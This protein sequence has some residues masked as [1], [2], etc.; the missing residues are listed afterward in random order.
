MI[1]KNQHIKTNQTLSIHLHEEKFYFPGETIKGTV[2]VHPKSPT[3]TNH[4]LLR[5]KGQVILSIKDKKSMTLFDIKKIL[6]DGQPGKV[7]ILEPKK[8]LFPF[9]F[10]VPSNLQLPSSMEYRKKAKVCY[11]LIVVHDR[12]MMLESL[13]P[14]IKYTVPVL[15]LIDIK[16]YHFKCIKERAANIVLPHACYPEKCY[17]QVSIAQYGFTRGDIASIEIVASHF[18]PYVLENA[19]TVELV[20]TIEIRT[21]RYSELKEDILRSVHHGLKIIGPYNFS[22]AIT[23]QLLIPTSTSPSIS[24]KSDTLQVRYKIRVSIQW[25]DNAVQ[26]TVIEMPIVIGTWPRTAVPIEDDDEEIISK[27]GEMMLSDESDDESDDY[28]PP[29]PRQ[30]RLMSATLPT[31]PCSSKSLTFMKQRLSFQDVS[32][33]DST[34]S[35]FSDQSYESTS[36]R[37]NN[38]WGSSSLSRNTSLST[39]LS[40]PNTISS[41]FHRLSVTAASIPLYHLHE[42]QCSPNE[43]CTRPCESSHCL[44]SD[45]PPVSPISQSLSP[46]CSNNVPTHV[47]QPLSLPS[48][49]IFSIKVYEAKETSDTENTDSDSTDL[50]VILKKK[51][52]KKIMQQ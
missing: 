14:R 15:E 35:R 48:E 21:D 36:S 2:H 33:S 9:E 10:N 31:S 25:N 12:P 40:S 50:L 43:N 34:V 39:D 19:V 13:L 44:V 45:Q 49:P 41:S 42:H 18:K 17:C 32:R 16:A 4:I 8:Y 5:F 30:H 6:A 11:E 24:F 23:S 52:K 51:K 3:K 1:L 29:L 38:S 46:H 20:R 37:T 27:M 22:Q 7:H 47:L 28:S 26:K